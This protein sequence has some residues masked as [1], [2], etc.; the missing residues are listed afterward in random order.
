[1]PLPRKPDCK[2]IVTIYKNIDGARTAPVY[3]GYRPAHRIRDDYLTSG[4]HTYLDT[5]ELH[6]G[7]SAF[8]NIVFITPEVYPHT[9]QSGSVLELHEGSRVIGSAEV[10]EVYNDIL[11]ILK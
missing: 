2:A 10:I 9:L 5:D 1:M 3:S 8:A 7:Q 6:P 11:R 4:T